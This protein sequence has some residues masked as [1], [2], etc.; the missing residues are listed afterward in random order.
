[1][2]KNAYFELV[3]REDGIYVE[4]IPPEED[5]ESLS[6]REV[7]SY[8]D[9]HGLDKYDLKKLNE[10]VCQREEKSLIRTGEAGSIGKIDES[11]EL[12]VFPDKMHATARF[13]PPANG[14]AL[15]TPQDIV[16]ELGKE[17][18]KV[19]VDQAQILSF[20]RDRRYATDYKIVQG[21]EPV[22]GHDA[23]VQYFF[24]TNM[25][26][27]PK[28][29]EDGSVDYKDLNTIGHVEAGQKIAQLI[30]EDPGKPGINVFGEEIRPHSVKSGKLAYG[31][32]ITISEDGTVLF[33]DVTGHASLVG[34]KIFVSD[35]YEVPADVDNSTGNIEYNGSVTIRG[36]V[37][38]GFRVNAK[39]DIVVEGIVEDA[40]LSS[41]G[42][43]IVKRGIHGMG[44]G[45]LQAKGNIICKFIENAKII[46]GGYVDAEAILHSQVD[47]YS[48]VMVNGKKGFISGGVI[49]AGNLVTA[50]TI[51][52][53]MVTITQI[54]VGV[55]PLEKE[56]YMELQKKI[57]DYQGQIEKIKPIV[58]TYSGKLKNGETFTQEQLSYI[59][60]LATQ[61][62]QLK[63]TVEPL[64]MEAEKISESIALGSSAR[65]KVANTIYSGVTISISDTK[66]TLKN[67]RAHSQFV[68]QDGEIKIIPL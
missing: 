64:E 7:T 18:I 59:R 44:K 47:A 29:N 2:G 17:R 49:R 52:S 33:S 68:R 58:V 63:E 27:R 22:Q 26:L 4:I 32:N 23:K 53:A 51:G 30:P 42:Q 15:L 16:S 35:V 38:G 61:L 21:R 1:M 25:N 67:E 43:I 20:I 8:L 28:R 10:A 39:G 31:N 5:G 66:M 13:Y 19:G 60:Q 40:V 11:M 57:K 56:H 3:T 24:N 12:S 37:K 62:R 46:S 54:E 48:D 6:I 9:R 14:G 45:I 36:N 55:D 50:K 34:G 41:G 65:V